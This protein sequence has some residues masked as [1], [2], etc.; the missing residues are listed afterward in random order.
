MSAAQQPQGEVP[1]NANAG[2]KSRMCALANPGVLAHVCSLVGGCMCVVDVPCAHPT[3]A[4]CGTDA[5]ALDLN[6]VRRHGQRGG[7][8]SGGLRRLSKSGSMCIDAQGARPR[9]SL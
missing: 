5:G 6:R 7:G 9:C 3:A 4:V 1:D 2:C 8:H